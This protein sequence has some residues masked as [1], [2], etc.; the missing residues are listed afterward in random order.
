MSRIAR[1]LAWLVFLLVVGCGAGISPTTAPPTSPNP[2]PA[3]TPTA[4]RNT[5]ARDAPPESLKAITRDWQTDWSRHT[6]DYSEL[7]SGG[8]PRDGIPPLDQP[9]FV[10]TEDA[11]AWLA[12]NEPIILFVH[13]DDA[14][15]YPLQI[16]TWHEIVNDTVRGLPVVVTFCPLCNSAVVFE[17]QI[18]GMEMTFGTSGLLRNSDLV[19]WDRQT[20]SLWQQFTGEGIVG[21]MTGAQLTFLPS[22]IISFAD[23]RAAYPQGRILS[24]ETGYSRR[25]GQNPYAGYDRIDQNPFLFTGEYDER[26]PAMARVVTVALP[27]DVFV[28]YPLDVLRE[29]GVINDQQGEQDLVV[30]YNGGTSSAL[31]A[32]IIAEGEDVGAT[33][34]FNPHVNGR[35][36]TFQQQAGGI[37]DDQTGSTWNVLGQATGGPL[38][39]E[40][41]P[42]IIHAD[43][44]WFAWAAFRPD[45]L[46]YRPD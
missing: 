12:G 1:H 41:L 14:R 26:L 13:N 42:P 24:R 4:P 34:V 16:L 20:E 11:A 2:P 23:F 38:M 44:F 27:G 7:L 46:I 30:F 5:P 21:E 28:A 36:L 22:A 43:H 3:A 10:T 25:Y 8:P 15:A 6:I 18:A 29:I 33:G 32:A 19:M 9:A 40:A 39:G 35:K 37:V 17:R 31:G 45:T